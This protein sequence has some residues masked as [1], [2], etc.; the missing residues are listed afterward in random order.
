MS[1]YWLIVVIVAVFA[2]AL[3][4]RTRGPRSPRPPREPEPVFRRVPP[5]EP[6]ERYDTSA[7]LATLPNVPMAELWCQRLREEGIEAF[8]K[9]AGVAPYSGIEGG[10]TVN[11]TWPAEVWI[12]Q[13]NVERAQ[14]LFPELA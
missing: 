5:L 8:I 12:G 2:A 4:A 14:Q 1:P 9:D 3:L 6:G 10:A 13:H 7:K 11:P